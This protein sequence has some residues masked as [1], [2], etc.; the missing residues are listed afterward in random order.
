MF[1]L[2][3]ITSVCLP[4]AELGVSQSTR[5]N[6]FGTFAPET[7]CGQT[8]ASFGGCVL[9]GRTRRSLAPGYG[10]E[11]CEGQLRKVPCWKDLGTNVHIL[12][13]MAWGPEPL[14]PHPQ[15]LTSLPS[16]ASGNDGVLLWDKLLCLWGAPTHG[17]SGGAPPQAHRQLSRP[18]AQAQTSQG[19]LLTAR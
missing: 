14:A 13:S 1:V 5:E 11:N 10:R 12:F 9:C 16:L 19:R 7:R 3:V 18:R 15:V 6:S 8:G 2:H 17:A 4:K